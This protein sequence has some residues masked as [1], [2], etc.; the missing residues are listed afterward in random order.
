MS[1]TERSPNFQ[2][3]SDFAGLI[4]RV[5][6]EV[7]LY[8][9]LSLGFDIEVL[10]IIPADCLSFFLIES[11]S[12]LSDEFLETFLGFGQSILVILRVH[13][14]Q[15]LVVRG[16]DIKLNWMLVVGE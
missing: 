2:E 7:V 14:T 6:L 12:L 5:Q 3:I 11:A 4:L 10:V 9:L 13:D 8:A 15:H 16:V 1:G